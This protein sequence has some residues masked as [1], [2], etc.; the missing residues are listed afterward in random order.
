MFHENYE[1]ICRLTRSTSYKGNHVMTK[2]IFLK[3]TLIASMLITIFQRVEASNNLFHG[4][5]GGTVMYFIMKSGAA[6]D[7]VKLRYEKLQ[8]K[9]A[10]LQKIGRINNQQDVQELKKLHEHLVRLK[11]EDYYINNVLIPCL[12]IGVG[13]Y[14][15][16]PN[17]NYY[18]SKI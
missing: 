16:W 5:L 4:V 2:N 1:Y 18:C 10:C 15:A 3:I 13:L 17:E 7:D 8:T 11:I 12:S 9:F 6:M 14:I